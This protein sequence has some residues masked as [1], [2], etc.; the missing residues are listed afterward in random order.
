MSLGPQ[1]CCVHGRGTFESFEANLP[2]VRL[3][4]KSEDP[5]VLSL[6]ALI[7]QDFFLGDSQEQELS[8]PSLSAQCQA[9]GKVLGYNWWRHEFLLGP[10]GRWHSQGI[11][12][13]VKKKKCCGTSLVVQWLRIRLAMQETWVQSLI[14]ELG[15]HRHGATKPEHHDSWAH[16]PQ[17]ESPCTTR[18]DPAWRSEIS[19]CCN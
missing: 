17:L 14:G 13:A 7:L 16:S 8:Q 3:W 2:S 19:M 5:S 1:H 6:R 18:K 9:H 12:Q 15:S 11:Y 10:L 4:P